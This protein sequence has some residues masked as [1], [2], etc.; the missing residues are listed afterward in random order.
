MKNKIFKRILI[1][2]CS[3]T[4]VYVV[5]LAFHIYKVTRPK[6]ADATTYA[7]ARI[8][9]KQTI[10]KE[11]AAK[12]TNWFIQ[13]NGVSQ[14]KCSPENHNAVFSFYPIKTNA[15]KLVE[16]FSNEL[17]YNA[18][19]FMPSKEEMMKGCPVASK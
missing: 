19:R 18:L 13:Q 9:F 8:D 14:F 11:D 15:N 17:H 6:V 3:V 1:A 2:I 12:I 16:T 4:L 7:M 5:L 10:T